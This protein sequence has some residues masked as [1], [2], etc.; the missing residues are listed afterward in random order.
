MITSSPQAKIRILS[1]EVV[2]RIAAGEVVERPA[3]VVK[4]LVDNSLD[5]GSTM[6]TIEVSDGGL[7]RIRVTDNGEGMTRED[8]LLAFRRHATSKLRSDQDLASIRTMGFRGEAVPSIAAVSKVRLMTTRRDDAVG[9][10]VE[11]VG[12]TVTS[13]ED[14]AAAPGTQ[15][16][17]TDLFFNT[18]ARR[19]FLRSTA[20]EVSHITQVVQQASLAWPQVH[21]RLTH[22]G[23]EVLHCAAVP[24]RRDRM[25][26]IYRGQFLDQTLA[27]RGERAGI[28]IEGV[29][30][31]ALHLRG[32]R[33]PQELFV[34]RRPV[35]N[36]T[37]L[38]AIADAYG[39]QLAK[40]RHVQFI[41]FVDVD[42][43]RIDVNVHPT[44]REVRFAEQD[45]IHQTVRQAVKTALGDQGD[46]ARAADAGADIAIPIPDRN[47]VAQS[48]VGLVAQ[49]LGLFPA[50][51]AAET[52]DRAERNIA[53]E[54][55][56]SGTFVSAVV[57]T[58]SALRP[59]QDV[60]AFGQVRQ[61]FLVAQLGTEL[62]VIDQHTAHERVLFQRLWRAWQDRTVQAQT[63]VAPLS[64]E[65][66][67][68]QSRLL[69]QY[70]ESLESCGFH[71]EPFGDRSFAVRTVPAILRMGDVAGVVQGI[72]E[73]LEEWG[74]TSSF[75]AR[76]QAMVA[77]LAC[78][79]AVRAGR[80]MALPEIAQ[81]VR[82][83]A[84]EGMVMTCPHGRRVAL[85][86]PF[87]DLN[88]LFGRS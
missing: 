9:S 54:A 3:A 32:T 14:A 63:L 25:L 80:S 33:S 26:Q 85:R 28:R 5:A 82:D 74:A 22:N 70:L 38:H 84:Q 46:G 76:M 58:E 15:M 75:D 78:H 24:T 71:V 51:V 60:V 34:N 87:D 68:Q 43:A 69:H 7:S 47:Y 30:V 27:V 1:A 73:D 67:A 35:K 83:W 44:K 39:A 36:P 61:T 17:V 19:K 79:S 11:V 16:D 12:G 48:T 53:M 52:I 49:T 42:P 66:T 8:A 13:V 6:I 29:T 37:I 81:L 65:T 64:V 4:E 45:V 77:T 10:K 62:Q 21:F 55:G 41:L 2:G 18:P 59:S 88:R 72:L 86:L 23:Q 56:S 40:G 20:T 57:G 31:D 50:S